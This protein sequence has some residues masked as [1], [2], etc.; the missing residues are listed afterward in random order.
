ML[1]YVI[2]KDGNIQYYED[3]A[4]ARFMKEEGDSLIPARQI[5]LYMSIRNLIFDKE[6]GLR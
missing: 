5:D 6:D 1:I 3:E 4:E 2:F